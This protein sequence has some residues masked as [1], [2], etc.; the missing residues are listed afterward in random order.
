MPG[1]TSLPLSSTTTS[2]QFY[3][4]TS[5][6]SPTICV[7][8]SSAYDFAS[9][10]IEKVEAFRGRVAEFTIHQMD[11]STC[12]VFAPT[13]SLPIAMQKRDILLS[14][15]PCVLWTLHMATFS[16]TLNVLCLTCIF[17]AFKSFFLLNFSQLP[18]KML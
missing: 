16:G 2:K 5:D 12:E 7:S 4:Q 15:L 17:S 6:H 9:C 1:S 14:V 8:Y 11:S 13:L 3:F 18:L 10:T